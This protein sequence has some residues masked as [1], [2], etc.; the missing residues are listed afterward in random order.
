MS[1]SIRAEH[2]PAVIRL[3]QSHERNIAMLEGMGLKDSA[4]ILRISWL[5]LTRSLHDISLMEIE[6]LNDNIRLIR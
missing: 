3:I 4:A 2:R 6:A 5:D 1:V